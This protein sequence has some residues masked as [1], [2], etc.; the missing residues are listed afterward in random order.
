LRNNDYYIPSSF[1]PSVASRA[2]QYEMFRKK[3]AY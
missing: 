1:P 2:C 3:Y